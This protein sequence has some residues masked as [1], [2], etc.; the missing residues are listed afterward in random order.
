MEIKRLCGGHISSGSVAISSAAPVALSPP[1]T[2]ASAVTLSTADASAIYVSHLAANL[3]NAKNFDVPEWDTLASYLAFLA[4]TPGPVSIARE[5]VVRS[6]SED[7]EDDTVRDDEEEALLFLNQLQFTPHHPA[8]RL[9]RR[10]ACPHRV[11]FHGWL[12]GGERVS[13]RAGIHHDGLPR[14]VHVLRLCQL[15]ADDFRRS[16]SAGV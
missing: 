8:T 16:P 10:L 4:P 7:T 6:A 15:I 9:L 3:V 13:A 11:C 12:T 1:C 5:R 14:T 2:E